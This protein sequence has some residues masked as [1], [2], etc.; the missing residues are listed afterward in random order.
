MPRVKPLFHYDTADAFPAKLSEWIGDVF[1]DI[2]P[3]HGYEVRDEQIYTAFQVGDAISGKNVHLAEAGLGTGKTFA[4]LLPAIAYARYS[5]K[6]V[7]IACATTALQEQLAGPN[8]DISALSKILGIEIDARMA[9]DPSQYLCDVRVSESKNFLNNVSNV[10]SNDLEEWIN[11]TKSGERSEMPLLSDRVWKQISWNEYLPCDMCSSRGFCKLIKAREHYRPTIDLII[12]DH[13]IFFKDLWT[14]D[15][16]IA[17]GK[18]PILPTYSGVVFDEGHKVILPAAMAAGTQI[19]KENIDN[20]IVT[21]EKIQDARKALVSIIGTLSQVS[22]EFFNKLYERIILDEGSERL[23]IKV[24]DQILKAASNLHKALDALLLE[25]QIEQELYI[26][27]VHSTDL[28]IYEGQ[29]DSAMMALMRFYRDKSKNVITWVDKKDNSF[30]VV[31]KHLDKRLEQNLYKKGLP[32]VFTS[33]TLSSKG[34][35]SY[36]IRTLGLTNP[37]FSTI[38]SPF[39]M[40][41]QAVVYLNQAIS[42]SSVDMSFTEK[43][44]KLASLLKQNKG[45]ALILTNSLNEVKKIR[46][47]LET[48]KLPFQFLWEDKGDRGYLVRTFREDVSSVL[49]GSN[50]WEGIDVPGDA[51]TL[52]IIWQMPFPTLDP[53]IES[54][55]KEAKEDGLDPIQAVDYPEMGLKLKQ[56]CGRLIRTQNDRGAIVILDSI[57]RSPWEKVVMNALPQGASIKSLEDFI[58]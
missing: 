17:D 33:A 13:E 48:Y 29:I 4:Y 20:I 21:L 58:K 52:L 16:R 44:T 23:A 46:K 7:V 55:R 43:I 3:E 41:E 6:P 39:D 9:K 49:I 32:I 27:S 38:E 50:F 26:E 57:V 11:K 45:Q 18:L 30:W 31:P 47:G 8:G 25:I 5:G 53:L 42:K 2:L 28:Q 51:L 22:S 56:G 14:R 19:I 1:Y 35:F 24:D 15:E 36:F 40:E 10:S 12:A 34:D 54:K 37:S